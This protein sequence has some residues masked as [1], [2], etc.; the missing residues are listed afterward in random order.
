ME[1]DIEKGIKESTNRLCNNVTNNRMPSATSVE[2]QNNST[3]I[4]HRTLNRPDSNNDFSSQPKILV[5][6]ECTREEDHDSQ[7]DE[8]DLEDLSH[9]A[10]KSFSNCEDEGDDE[11]DDLGTSDRDDYYGDSQETLASVLSKQPTVPL[12]E[13][14][15]YY[16]Y[17]QQTSLCLPKEQSP[18]KIDEVDSNPINNDQLQDSKDRPSTQIDDDIQE[19]EQSIKKSKVRAN[20]VLELITS[21]RDF[22]KHLRDVIEGYLYPARRHPEMFNAIR[23]STIFSNIEQ[24]YDFQCDFLNRLESCI[25]W[26][27]LSASEVGQC[28]L[29]YEKG[30]EV[31][32]H[33]CNNHPNAISELQ[34]LYVKPRYA[35]FFEACRLLRSMIDISLD[36]FLLTPIQKICKYPLQLNE[37]LKH[38]PKDH[39]DYLPVL[40][41]LESMRNCANLANERKRRI[42]SLADLIS[43]QDKIENWFGQKLWETSSILIHYGEVTKMTSH[44]W[45]QGVQL[46]LFDHLLVYFKKD[47]LKR[48]NLIMRGR[49]CM[50]TVTEVVDVEEYKVRKSF[51]LY[52]SEQQK[53]FV[54]T[55]RNQK[56]KEEW[57]RSFARER[58]IVKNDDLQGFRI[59][60]REVDVAT[61][62]LRSRNHCR[63]AR[64]RPKRP[65]T[66]IVDHLDLDIGPGMNRTLSLPS[67]IHP[68]HVLTFFEE[69][70]L[71]NNSARK[72]PI[73]NNSNCNT[74]STGTGWFRKMGSKKLPKNNTIKSVVA[75]DTNRRTPTTIFYPDFET[76]NQSIITMNPN[77]VKDNNQTILQTDPNRYVQEGYCRIRED[78]V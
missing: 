54:F 32:Y 46:Y 57:L 63:S 55:T 66:T 70:K 31:Y 23:I 78:T 50:D 25:K 47:L 15:A 34:D 6:D 59:T 10:Q 5:N 74:N 35:R 4:R 9:V 19:K 77:T 41:A 36:G 27:H 26:S 52:C 39:E 1:A 29:D 24:L 11:E 44:T 62:A 16:S 12:H 18:I 40:N 75:S 3:V 43:L 68:N 72:K 73:T 42:E 17:I 60:E 71:S 22:V 49:V 33:Y 30:F 61:R 67:C 13:L 56:E 64:Y 8:S 45:S 14:I 65:D 76:N 28:F 37:L 7:N 69:S 53:W 51:K 20:V 48:N 21:E 58:E 2:E 38:T